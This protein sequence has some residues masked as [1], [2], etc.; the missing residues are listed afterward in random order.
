MIQTIYYFIKLR[1]KRPLTLTFFSY[2]FF[3]CGRYYQNYPHFPEQPFLREIFLIVSLGLLYAAWDCLFR[4]LGSNRIYQLLNPVTT[5]I[6]II[7]RNGRIRYINPAG[8]EIIKRLSQWLPVESNRIY[9]FC[10]YEFFRESEQIRQVIRYLGQPY[11]EELDIGSELIETQ[12]VPIPG[13]SE[14]IMIIWNVVTRSRN[15]SRWE[16]VVEEQIEDTTTELTGASEELQTLSQVMEQMSQDT[17]DQARDVTLII[18]NVS[19]RI[20]QLVESVGKTTSRTQEIAGHIS[21]STQIAAQ[22][23]SESQS[24]SAIIQNLSNMANTISGMTK[25]IKDIMEQTRILAI[26]ANIEAAKAGESGKGFS[27]IATHIDKLA[28]QTGQ[29]SEKITDM[30]GKILL[31]TPAS[32]K[33]IDKVQTVVQKMNQ[34][35]LNIKDLMTEQTVVMN[36]MSESM[37]EA[38]AESQQIVMR[39]DEIVSH[40]QVSLNEV[41]N[42]MDAARKIEK[43]ASVFRI[44]IQRFREE[45]IVTPNDIYRMLKILDRM[46]DAWL[47]KQFSRSEFQKMTTLQLK[48]FQDKKPVDVL[49]TSIDS[50][51]IFLGLAHITQ[52]GIKFPK[53]AVTPTQTYNFLLHWQELIEKALLEHQIA[54]IEGLKKAKPVDEKTPNDA[55]AVIKL[56][57]EKL[58]CLRS[59][60]E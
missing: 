19:E 49:Q 14:C 55:Y 25:H 57:Q 56:I 2:V 6:M 32:V 8:Q 26:N 11:K 35:M 12:A 7:D 40:S 59:H 51:K 5:A 4:R 45:R 41:A 13:H 48:S 46:L 17:L 28:I 18:K 20:K 36:Q 21:N 44:I 27:V 10:Y 38:G 33:S 60:H 24:A 29:V 34:N 39:M 30:I 15:Q 50:A 42:E 23:L 54:D 31:Q 43:I 1:F 58:N 3:W 53:G 37:T 16:K 9:R 22:A 47:E 52:K